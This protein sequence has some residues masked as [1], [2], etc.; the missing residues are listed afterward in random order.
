MSAVEQQYPDVSVKNNIKSLNDVTVPDAQHITIVY[1]DTSDS[2][3]YQIIRSITM[4]IKEFNQKGADII[5]AF[6][7]DFPNVSITDYVLNNAID[8]SNVKAINSLQGGQ[9]VQ[10]TNVAGI[11]Q[12]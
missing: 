3:Q 10:V 12:K 9:I 6:M 7:P 1:N 5:K 4:P 2:G 8:G 11:P